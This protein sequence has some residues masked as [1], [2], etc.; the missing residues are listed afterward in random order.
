MSLAAN[1]PS[2]GLDPGTLTG[3]LLRGYDLNRFAGDAS[4]VGDAELRIALGSYN[5]V[6]PTRFGLLGL[7]DVGRVFYP[8]ESSRKW[9]VGAGGGLW[10]T[11][12]LAVPG[13]RIVTTVNTL[14]VAS[15]EGTKFSL[16][17]GFGF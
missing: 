5:S 6:P 7:T 4:L 13:Y 11:I 10:A 12:L 9:H 3:N 14:V 8:P 2:F 17:S 1:P 15:E 16:S